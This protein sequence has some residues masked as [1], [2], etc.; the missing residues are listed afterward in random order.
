VDQTPLYFDMPTNTTIDGKGE[1]ECTY[2]KKWMRKAALHCD[3]RDNCGRKKVAAVCDKLPNVVHVR[4][5]DKG[6]VDV[7]VVCDWVRTV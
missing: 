2:P 1:K 5:Q 6:R 3:A 7:A 4:V